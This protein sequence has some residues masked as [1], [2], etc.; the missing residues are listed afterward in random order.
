MILIY[1]DPN[2]IESIE[3]LNILK[4]NKKKHKIVKYL[5]NPP[6]E[7]KLKKIVNKL[8][9]RPYNLIKTEDSLWKEHYQEFVKNEGDFEDIEYIKVLTEFPQLIRTPIVVKGK[10]AVL[11]DPPEKVFS[12]I[13][14]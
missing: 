5:E 7:N 8:D 2:S 9:I 14:E 3:C 10:K 12:F 13:N 11:C 1:H 4:K 6:T